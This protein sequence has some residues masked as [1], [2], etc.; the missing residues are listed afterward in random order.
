MRVALFMTAAMGFFNMH[1]GGERFFEQAVQ[2]NGESPV[3]NLSVRDLEVSWAVD[4]DPECREAEEMMGLETRPVFN[5]QAGRC[6]KR[7]GC[8]RAEK[9][10]QS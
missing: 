1:S 5:K 9:L 2:G 3:H 6:C 7:S 4:D 10:R 8:P